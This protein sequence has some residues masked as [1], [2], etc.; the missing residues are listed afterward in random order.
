[1]LLAKLQKILP[2]VAIFGLLAGVYPLPP[3]TSLSELRKA[4]QLRACLPPSYPP[5][6]TGEGN[7]PGIDVELLQA[8]AKGMGVHLGAL[9]YVSNQLSS[10]IYPRP[11]PMAMAKT[12]GAPA[13]PLAIEPQ[14]VTRNANVYAVYAIE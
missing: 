5:L 4:G 14:K 3:D 7:A 12:A 1:M 13:P 10:P 11:M 9:I 8:L 2:Y 6:V